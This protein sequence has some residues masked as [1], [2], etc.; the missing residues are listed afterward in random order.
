MGHSDRWLHWSLIYNSLPTNLSSAFLGFLLSPSRVTLST[1]V[2]TRSCRRSKA[3]FCMS[4]YDSLTDSLSS[5]PYHSSRTLCSDS[6]HAAPT[7]SSRSLSS[8]AVLQNPSTSQLTLIHPSTCSLN[9]LSPL[10]P[11]S[12]HVSMPR[13]PPRSRES[14][15][16]PSVLLSFSS[17]N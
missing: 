6:V 17:G 3:D 2:R 7:L 9:S 13:L 5:L 12:L 4:T 1:T 14:H 8:S 15:P 16:S 10:S 11:S